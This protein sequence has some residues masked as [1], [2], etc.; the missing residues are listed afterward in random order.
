M[1]SLAMQRR[2]REVADGNPPPFAGLVFSTKLENC[3]EFPFGGSHPDDP[4]MLSGEGSYFHQ[5]N[6][7]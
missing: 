1:R 7:F 5:Y 3:Q 6:S 4:Q 2:R